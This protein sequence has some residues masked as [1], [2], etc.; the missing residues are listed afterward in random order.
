MFEVS[1]KKAPLFSANKHI[2]P[3]LFLTG[4]FKRFVYHVLRLSQLFGRD[5]LR[6]GTTLRSEN[7]H[8]FIVQLTTSPKHL[9]IPLHCYRDLGSAVR[10]YDCPAIQSP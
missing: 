3:I 10:A 1:L 9:N 2:G 4:A 8:L 7:G 6:I 5:W